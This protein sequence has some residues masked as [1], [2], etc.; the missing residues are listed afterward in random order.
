MKQKYYTNGE[1]G[2]RRPPTSFALFCVKLNQRGTTRKPTKRLSRK[3]WVK[4]G[5]TAGAEIWSRPYLDKTEFNQRAAQLM[6][7]H[8]KR[9]AEAV[10]EKQKAASV[11]ASTTS[12]TSACPPASVTGQGTWSSW[13]STK[14]LGQG[15]YGKVYQVVE[16]FTATQLAMKVAYNTHSLQDL[17]HER[18][19]ISRMNS[20]H[21]VQQ[22]GFVTVENDKV[23]MLLE[24]AQC[25]LKFWLREHPFEEDAALPGR[26][27]ICCQLA[28]GLLHVHS[29]HV[30]HC[31][32]KTANVLAFPG[33]TALLVKISDFGLA[34]T[35]NRAPDKAGQFEVVG[36]GA[37]TWCFRAPELV[38]AS[39]K[40][41]ISY[42]A[43]VFALGCVFFDVFRSP[44]G[45]DYLFPDVALHRAM[46]LKK[47]SGGLAA[48]HSVMCSAR[49]ERL[50]K[51]L[52]CDQTAVD[53]VKN[54]AKPTQR[55]QLHTVISG[56][57]LAL[58]SGAF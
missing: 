23:A 46:R 20:P 31:D 43:D 55:A 39:G 10:A 27:R 19:I 40:A 25:D 44:A 53:M 34:M 56:C 30:L 24:L 26:W 33:D 32:V 29:H 2:L 16:S 1:L 35:E 18:D 45:S 57:R 17:A 12:S 49:D 37:Y 5:R 36:N 38:L 21:V 58:G 4:S 48:A 41:L 8:L 50:R 6:T 22:F 14:L 47:Q 15:T 52:I 7:E 51:R 13:S 54:M 3:T 11:A 9:K 28:T 42:T